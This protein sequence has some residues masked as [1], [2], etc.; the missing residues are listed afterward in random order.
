MCMEN[1]DVIQINNIRFKYDKEYV[2][3]DLTIAI[4]EKKI[5]TFLGANGCGKT[6][7]LYLL[8]KHMTPNEGEMYLNGQGYSEYGRKEFAKKIAIVHQ[9]NSAPDD[10]SV[11]NLV[12]YGRI[13]HRGLQSNNSK[14]DLEKIEWALQVSDLLSLKK[15]RFSELSGGQK[16]RVWIAMALAQDTEII[17]FDEPTTYLDIH[18]QIEVLKLIKELNKTYQKTII[19]ILHD[20]NQAVH[21]S[22]EIVLFE[23]DSNKIHQ[24]T[25]ESV[26]ND[27]NLES[28]FQK[29][30]ALFEHEG[31][32]VV[33]T[34]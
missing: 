23:K 2:L 10:I 11:E 16:Q 20:I 17:L 31:R 21:Y 22:D 9:Q 8:S 26:I 1:K 4:K 7:L 5:T 28:A 33:L 3:D 25:P 19:M 6:T 29:K 27:V 12:G 15:R 34:V 14:E 13:P 32:K 24:G 30:L 18:Y